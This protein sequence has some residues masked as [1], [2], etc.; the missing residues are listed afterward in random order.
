VVGVNAFVHG[1]ADEAPACFE[2]DG[3]KV[4]GHQLRRIA[5]VKLRRDAQHVAR[6]LDALET[7]AREGTGNL[8]ALTIRCMRARATVGECTRALEAVW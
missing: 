8:L 2:L 6:A 3:K 1:D 7:A 5:E 4:R